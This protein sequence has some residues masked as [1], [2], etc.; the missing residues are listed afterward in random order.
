SQM[1]NANE[2]AN[3]FLS[4]SETFGSEDSLFERAEFIQNYLR[5]EDSTT[6]NGAD[7]NPASKRISRFKTKLRILEIEPDSLALATEP[8]WYVFK[9]FITRVLKLILL[10]PLSIPGTLLHFPAYQFIKLLAKRYT[11]HGLDDII[12]TVKILAGAVFMPLTWLTSAIVVYYFFGLRW[13]LISFPLAILCG[14]AALFSLEELEDLGDWFHAT[15]LFIRKRRILLELLRE[16][17]SI[18]RD[19]KR[20]I[21]E[22]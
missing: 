8:F 16:Q 11:N 20:R 2:A 4:V 15:N 12:S 17:R 13:S 1:K 19:I 21:A 22:N 3:L 6:G 7:G 18:E 10:L 9:Q 5:A 14:Y